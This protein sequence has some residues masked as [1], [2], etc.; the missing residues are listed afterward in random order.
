MRSVKRVIALLTAGA[1]WLGAGA[2]LA[3]QPQ[4][5]APTGAE[6]ASGPWQL[7]PSF[8]ITGRVAE[9]AGHSPTTL[10]VV[11]IIDGLSNRSVR[12]ELTDSTRIRQ[13]PLQK[14]PADLHVGSLVWVHCEQDKG[15]I[16]AEDIQ[17]LDPV[18]PSVTEAE[19]PG[20]R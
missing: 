19:G 14:G 6:M 3:A 7:I 5:A 4:D 12:L 16:V 17:I 18:V 2:A 9:I 8:R 10:T 15:P 11:G 1:L 13:G 20:Y